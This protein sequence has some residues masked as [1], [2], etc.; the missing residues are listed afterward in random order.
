MDSSHQP[1][2][3][4]LFCRT[5]ARIAE[6]PEFHF[7]KLLEPGDIEIIHNP[8]ILHGRDEVEDGEVTPLLCCWV[9]DVTWVNRWKNDRPYLW[10]QKCSLDPKST[11]SLIW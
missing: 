2:L 1:E 6:D 3:H 11:Y 8:T 7:T 4:A 9:V 10:L 5:F